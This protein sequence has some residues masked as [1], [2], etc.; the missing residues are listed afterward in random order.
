M[1][2]RELMEGH[3]DLVLSLTRELVPNRSTPRVTDWELESG[4][5][6]FYDQVLAKLR[7]VESSHF[8]VIAQPASLV[9][10]PNTEIAAVAAQYGKELRRLGFSACQVVHIYGALCD[11]ITQVAKQH[12]VT[13]EVI[14]YIVLN[15]CLDDAIGEAVTEYEAD[16][17]KAIAKQQDKNFGFLMHE[18]RNALSNAVF[19]V[20]LIKNGAVGP[21]GRTAATLDRSLARLR[22]LIDRSLTEVRLRS[23]AQPLLTRF[24]IAQILEEIETMVTPEVASRGIRLDVHAEQGLEL[25]ADRHMIVSAVANLVQNAIKFTHEGGTVQIRACSAA[26]EWMMIEVEDEC[27]GLPPERAEEL[28]HPVIFRTT[29]PDGTGLGLAIVHQAVSLHR[30]QVTVANRPGKGCVF[31]IYLGRARRDPSS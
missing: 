18:L 9:P 13:I 12:R 7:D 5:P 14:E 19:A 31:T 26:G 6:A 3:R 23:D 10:S 8:D 17:D 29:D 27:G 4:L 20:Q 28:A 15:R 1:G 11:S 24:D 30:G 21:S 25:E 22:D 2:L 16:R